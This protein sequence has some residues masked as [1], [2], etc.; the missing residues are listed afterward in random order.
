MTKPYGTK[1]ER[2]TVE[3]VAAALK[4]TK[5]L[6]YLAAKRLGCCSETVIAYKNRYPELAAA[7]NEAR[8]EMVDVAQAG[9]YKA[10]LEGKGWAICFTLKTLGRDRGFV[11]RIEVADN[12]PPLYPVKNVDRVTLQEGKAREE[13]ALQEASL[14]GGSGSLLEPD[15][16]VGAVNENAERE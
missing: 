4:E 16:E 12:A 3:Q 5:G 11:Q 8:G 13:A 1:P 6:V 14:Q 2:Y 10:L 15:A 9:L 7:A